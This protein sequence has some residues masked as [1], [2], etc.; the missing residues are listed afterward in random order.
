MMKL[1]WQPRRR[2][3]TN[4]NVAGS[5][6]TE[7]AETPTRCSHMAS[8]ILWLRGPALY[9]RDSAPAHS[10]SKADSLPNL[11]RY[12][13]SKQTTFAS[14]GPKTRIWQLITFNTLQ[15]PPIDT[16]AALRR[17]QPT[18][19]SGRERLKICMKARRCGRSSCFEQRLLFVALPQS[20]IT[21]EL[22]KTPFD[23][24]PCSFGLQRP[25]AGEEP[26]SHVP[27]R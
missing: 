3:I 1:L 10:N 2:L 22:L 19:S 9:F 26:A 20:G 14:Y 6:S 12:A 25:A 15:R 4:D 24:S 21:A 18:W 5:R 23:P 16:A 27:S 11:P 8:L 7:S 13:R 17:E